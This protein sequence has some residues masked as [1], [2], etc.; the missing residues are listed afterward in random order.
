MRQ[1][2]GL[3]P[4][5]QAGVEALGVRAAQYDG[6]KPLADI[7]CI[8]IKPNFH[9]FHGLYRQPRMVKPSVHMQFLTICSSRFSAA[10]TEEIGE[11]TMFTTEAAGRLVAP[12]WAP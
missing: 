2:L 7:L 11:L 10:R 4:H 8:G 9:Q 3:L 12:R 6:A 5:D 1:R